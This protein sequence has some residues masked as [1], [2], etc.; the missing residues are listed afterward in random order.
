MCGFAGIWWG[1]ADPLR[2]ADAVAARMVASIAHR[3][4]D[5]GSW[6]RGPRGI[7]GFRRLSIIDP[8][9]GHQPVRSPDGRIEALLNGEIYNHRDL[10]P[11]VEADGGPLPSGSDAEV[12][13]GL[14]RR[15]GDA[16]VD[17]LSGMFAICVADHERRRL[18]LWR[19]RFGIKPMF[20]ARVGP[21]LLFGSEL[22]SILASGLLEPEIDRASLAATLERMHAPGPWTMVAG[23]RSLPPGG[24]LT[25]E[26]DGRI[27]LER[28]NRRIPPPRTEAGRPDPRR[29]RQRLDEAVAAQLV[30]DVPLGIA[31]SGGI[32]S[33]LLAESAARV[34]R[35]SDPPLTAITVD[36]PGMPPE[37]VAFAAATAA[38]LGM[39][40]RIVRIPATAVDERLPEVAWVADE[41]VTDPATLSS[42]QL[43]EAAASQVRVLLLGAGGDELFGGYPGMP[44]G[45]TERLWAALPAPL[46]T[47]LIGRMAAGNPRRRDRLEAMGRTRRSRMAMHLL[48]RSELP[49]EVRNELGRAILPGPGS[50]RDPVAA[51]REA[52]DAAIECDLFTQQLHADLETYLPDQLLAMLDR[53]SMAAGIEGRVPLLDEG[54]AAAA[55]AIHG[56]WKVGPGG[57]GKRILRSMLEPAG[58]AALARRPKSGFASPVAGWLNT[59]MPAALGRLIDDPRSISATILAPGWVRRHLDATTSR[60][61][62]DAGWLHGLT[63]IELWHR[64][65]LVDRRTD[66]PTESIDRLLGDRPAMPRMLE[67]KPAPRQEFAT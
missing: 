10:R 59:G 64:L 13:P 55:M 34:R 30:A 37:E 31:L 26:A 33:T 41:P 16:F 19:D 39:D 40:H 3:G 18:V 20:H 67:P 56:R 22:K 49:P 48:L 24:R 54:F 15:H 65:L 53:T 58:D 51:V 21:W 63:M 60:T 42:L 28:W 9:G 57:T 1:E 32:D 27:T 38:R 29:L 35:P 43:C 61:W 7:V 45:R 50:D 5:E 66:R 44:I 25:M 52:F 17:R 62:R 4:P 23:I 11:A 46:R 14:Y 2:D 47:R 36:G 12:I 6:I 8:T